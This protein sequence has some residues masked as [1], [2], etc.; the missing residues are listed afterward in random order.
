VE[1]GLRLEPAAA[2][3][4]RVDLGADPEHL[5]GPAVLRCYETDRVYTTETYVDVLQTYSG[6]R[7]MDR[8]ALDGLLACIGALID[9]RYGG[10]I[11]KRYLRT[12]RVARR[13]A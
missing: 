4:A 1:E 13:D 10:M 7:A 2:F 6:M 5:L 3:A 9:S 11:V 8:D 12:M